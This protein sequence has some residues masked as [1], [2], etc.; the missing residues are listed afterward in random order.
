MVP[1]TFTLANIPDLSVSRS[2]NR[3]QWGIPVP[4]DPSQT[5][6][7]WLDA[8][9]NYLTV[10]G[11][12]DRLVSLATLHIEDLPHKLTPHAKVLLRYPPSAI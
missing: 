11:F 1:V 10:A 9:T 7:V 2:R 5:I 12:P 3:L 8:L 4:G 6:Y